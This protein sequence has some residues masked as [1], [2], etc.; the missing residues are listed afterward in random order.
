ME[1]RGAS[2]EWRH[3]VPEGKLRHGMPERPQSSSQSRCRI[4]PLWMD[5]GSDP[6]G[7]GQGRRGTH[8]TAVVLKEAEERVEMYG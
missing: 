8:L 4:Q 7:E 2:R 6:G 3:E 1:A 5:A